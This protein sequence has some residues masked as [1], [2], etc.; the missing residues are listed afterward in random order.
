[1]RL[2]DSRGRN[3]MKLNW[4]G[5]ERKKTQPLKILKTHNFGFLESE[6]TDTSQT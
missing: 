1:M 3:V 4:L 5:F 6:K 2:M